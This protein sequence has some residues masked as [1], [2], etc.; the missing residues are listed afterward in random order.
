MKSI[1]VP[2]W[3]DKSMYSSYEVLI[4]LRGFFN[5]KKWFNIDTELAFF[6]PQK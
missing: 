5:M 1:L 2:E 3:K 6:F 4:V